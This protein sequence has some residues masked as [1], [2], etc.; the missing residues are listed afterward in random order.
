[1]ELPQGACAL[2]ADIQAP[3]DASKEIAML[4]TLPSRTT[5][6]I[7]FEYLNWLATDPLTRDQTQSRRL[8]EPT[9]RINTIDPMTGRDIEDVMH[10]PSLVDGNLTVYFGTE[11]ARRNYIDMPLNHPNLRLPY[12]ATD[13]DDRGG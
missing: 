8:H 11:V 6:A 7:R 9:H 3:D 5:P 13:E 10:H 4:T 2:R 12:P 1:M